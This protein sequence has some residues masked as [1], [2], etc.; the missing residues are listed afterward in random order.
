MSNDGFISWEQA[1]PS[2]LQIAITGLS[3]T[4]M[5]AGGSVGS[6]PLISLSTSDF[7][8]FSHFEEA[9][10][11]RPAH[12]CHS[13]VCCSDSG[14]PAGAWWNTLLGALLVTTGFLCFQKVSPSD[15]QKLLCSTAKWP[16]F[17]LFFSVPTPQVRSFSS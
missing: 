3:S 6:E 17:D 4:C 1:E 7:V 14:T 9:C 16:D 12:V 11:G 8:C 10:A 13:S 15:P 5:D 2:V